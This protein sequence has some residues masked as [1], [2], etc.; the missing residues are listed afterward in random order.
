MKTVNVDTSSSNSA[1]ENDDDEWYVGSI[2]IQESTHNTHEVHENTH[3]TL[4]VQ[5]NTQDILGPIPFSLDESGVDSE[6]EDE[7]LDDELLIS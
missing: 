6:S 1:D 2:K 7:T 5:E 3:S 4:A